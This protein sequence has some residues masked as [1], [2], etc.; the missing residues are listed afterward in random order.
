MEDLQKDKNIYLKQSFS[1]S[2]QRSHFFSSP[3]A[4]NLAAFISIS[5]L[6]TQLLKLQHVLGLF[7]FISNEMAFSVA[8]QSF[9]NGFSSGLQCSMLC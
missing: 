6:P 8:D 1:Q 9:E 5:L 4:V 2:Q 3:L 7:H